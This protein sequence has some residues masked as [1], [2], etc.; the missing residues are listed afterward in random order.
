MKFSKQAL[1]IA[2]MACAGT[3]VAAGCGGDSEGNAASTGLPP[4][5]LLSDITED[6]AQQACERLRDSFQQR[7]NEQT[8]IESFCTMYSAAVATT[9]D[10]CND[11]RDAC[12]E[13][14]AQPGSDV[15]DLDLDAIDFG[16]EMAEVEDCGDATV[17]DLER[18]FNDTLNLLDGMLNRYSCADAAMVEADDLEGL[19]FEPAPSCEVVSCGGTDGPF[20]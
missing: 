7:F 1:A 20:G 4:T 15:M 19:D 17:A 13:E 14:A 8:L 2:F 12:T 5:K 6:E 11:F 16:C 10:S 9:P 18:C 3:G